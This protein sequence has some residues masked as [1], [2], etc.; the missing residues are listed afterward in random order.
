[1]TC[2]SRLKQCVTDTL[3]CQLVKVHYRSTVRAFWGGGG[4]AKGQ[5][6]PLKVA[7]PRP[8][9]QFN[10]FLTYTKIQDSLD[11]R[12]APSILGSPDFPPPPLNFFQEKSVTV[13]VGTAYPLIFIIQLNPLN[14]QDDFSCSVISTKL[15]G[16]S[17]IC[18]MM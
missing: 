9:T 15:G 5:L 1:M 3:E 4:G 17:L 16:I 2:M 14:K 10:S 6:A 12:L 7:L 8:E 13:H 18:L 11:T